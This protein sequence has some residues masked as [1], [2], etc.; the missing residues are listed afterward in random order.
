MNWQRPF[1][2]PFWLARSEGG[3]FDSGAIFLCAQPVV[4]EDEVWIGNRAIILGGTHLGRGC[5]V[6][7]GAVVQGDFPAGSILAGKPAEI[8]T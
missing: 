1:R 6:A 7:A 8:V 3:K 2:R 5:V 4:L